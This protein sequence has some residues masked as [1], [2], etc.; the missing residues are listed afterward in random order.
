MTTPL[1]S[2]KYR[3]GAAALRCLSE[4]TTYFASPGELNDSLEAKF[5]VSDAESFATVI[6]RTLTELSLRSG[7]PSFSASEG[8]D[9]AFKGA[10]S[11]ESERFIQACQQVG[12][13][14]CA[15]R[16]DNQPMWS[17]Y[18]GNERGVCLHLEWPKAIIERYHLHPTEVTY[19]PETR[20]VNRAAHYRQAL[21]RLAAQNPK[22]SLAQLKAF[23]LTEQFRLGVGMSG[24]AEAVS[25]KHADWQHEQEIRM[26]APRSGPLPLMRDILKSVI[27]TRP[28]FP[29]WGAIMMLLHQL[30]P[31]VRRVMMTFS[32]R[33]PLVT[34]QLMMTKLVPIERELAP[35][36]APSK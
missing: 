28:D 34:S 3:T 36:G 6:G 14:S 23:S 31:S 7:G 11:R 2:Y 4:G 30:Y 18:C 17:Y 9:D 13:Y 5:D 22:W 26:L 1:V 8:G 15:P 33:E 16:P 10:N 35:W 29:E 25:I 19:S 32:H 24:I 12:I 27:Y 20:L 21:L